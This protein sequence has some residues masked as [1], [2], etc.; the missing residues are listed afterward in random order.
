MLRLIQPE[1]A[2]YVHGLRINP[3]YNL[4]LSEVRGTA[5]DQRHWIEN[6]KTREAEGREF[7]YVIERKDGTPCGVVRLYEIKQD[8]FTWGSW[9]LDHNKP[10]K[11]AL[12]SAYLVYSAAFDR[13][14]L[15]L[16]A[17]DVRRENAHTIAFHRR[18]GATEASRDKQNIYFVYPRSRYDADRASFS[19]ILTQ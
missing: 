16:A 13:L 1:D 4:H 2:V 14:G 6:Y 3:D 19:M 8:S 12:E 11:A 17:F 7:Y 10:A 15:T 9:I 18:F 5:D